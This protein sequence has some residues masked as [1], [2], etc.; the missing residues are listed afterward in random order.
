MFRRLSCNRQHPRND[1]CHDI[2]EGMINSLSPV[3]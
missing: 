3:E 1:N 2:G